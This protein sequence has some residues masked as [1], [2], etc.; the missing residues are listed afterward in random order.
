MWN[1]FKNA[2][3][4]IPNANSEYVTC[5]NYLVVRFHQSK[6]LLSFVLWNTDENQKKPE[7]RYSNFCQQA[8]PHLAI[9]WVL[10]TAMT[11]TKE[12]KSPLI[13]PG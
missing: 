7:R 1:Y 3:I 5:K 13:M 4:K 6:I 11:H 8:F 9:L 12:E 10:Y 2:L